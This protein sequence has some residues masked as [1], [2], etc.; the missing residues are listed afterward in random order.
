MQMPHN[1]VANGLPSSDKGRSVSVLHS[2]LLI[3]NDTTEARPSKSREICV[4][5]DT[6]R[7]TKLVYMSAKH[8]IHSW[9]RPYILK[10]ELAPSSSLI[11]VSASPAR[12]ARRR[13]VVRQ[14]DVGLRVH[15]HRGAIRSADVY[16]PV[17]SPP[18]R[19]S[20]LYCAVLDAGR[21]QDSAKLWLLWQ[22]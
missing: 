20:A 1:Q 6:T 9:S 21:M 18:A 4:S 11:L 19:F 3:R 10:H 16:H 14:H 17:A 13:D 22:L 12:P 2:L 5:Q 7:T 15:R 8:L